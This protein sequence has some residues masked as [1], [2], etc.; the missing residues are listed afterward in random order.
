MRVSGDIGCRPRRVWAAGLMDVVPERID[1]AT[2]G[3]APLG[4]ARVGR[5]PADARRRPAARARRRRAGHRGRAPRVPRR[6]SPR[7]R[8]AMWGWTD[9]LELLPHRPRWAL[10]GVAELDGE[11]ALGF[12]EAVPR[13]AV[14]GWERF[15]ARVPADVRDAVRRAPARP[16]PAVRGG[17]RHPADVPPRRLEVRQPRD[18]GRRT[19]RAARLGLPGRAAPWPTSWPGTCRSTTPGSRRAHEG[20]DHRRPPGRPRAPRRSTPTAGGTASSSCACSA[21]L[22]QFGWEKAYGDDDELGWWVDRARRAGA[23][24]TSPARA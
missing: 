5:R 7:C 23:A 19:G 10:F 22:V 16:D 11:A 4:T 2:L 14:E 13:I 8:R 3:V 15:D 18:G 9:D 20:V 24:V 6:A 1:H 21:R 17:P 12:P